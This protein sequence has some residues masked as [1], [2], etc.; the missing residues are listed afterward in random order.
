MTIDEIEMS[1]PNGLHDSELTGLEIDYTNR[2]AKFHINVNITPVV[3][4]V[5]DEQ[6]R[7]GILNVSGL[8]FCVSEPPDPSYPYSDPTG[9]W[10]TNSGPVKSELELL[11]LELLGSLPK[12]SFAHYLFID[13]WNAC[14]YIAA[15]DA[16]FEWL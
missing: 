16:R 7:L 3:Q 9:L 13:E 4:E 8:L 15:R 5:A 12:D 11:P 10:I 1:L 6:Y 14:I 2:T